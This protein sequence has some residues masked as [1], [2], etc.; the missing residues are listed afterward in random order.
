[1]KRCVFSLVFGLCI[2]LGF[3]WG[4]WA[5]ERIN[6]MAVFSLPAEM[7]VL[8]KP[9]LPY[10]TRHATDPD[11][12][13][14]VL[15]GEA[16]RHYWDSEKYPDW[17][18]G[19][20]LPNWDAAKSRWGE[21][22]L[23]EH[24]MLPFHLE[25]AYWQ[26]KSAFEAG[27]KP[28]ILKAS[29]DLG[30]YLGDAHVPLHTTENYNGQLTGQKGIHGFWE[31]RLPELFALE[32]DYWVGRA[33]YVPSIRRAAW[34]IVRDSHA[35]VE[36]VLALEK[37]LQGQFPP[38]RRYAYE[39]RNGQVVRCYSRSYSEA[40]HRALEGMVEA[41][42]RI[43]IRT[44]ASWWYT[45]WKDAG[46]PDLRRLN[47]MILPDSTTMDSAH[48]EFIDRESTEIGA[49]LPT[50]GHICCGPVPVKA[51]G[52]HRPIQ[53]ILPKQKAIEPKWWERWLSWILIA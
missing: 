43:S 45:A 20:T 41:R 44:V 12:R 32:Y 46:S 24:G 19:D 5:H 23:L 22:Y 47:L 4:F 21:A 11:K 3:G 7:L 26:L 37:Q 33:A 48:V 2:K 51:F 6:R 30:H 10:L 42:L 25:R 29:A 50:S 14:Y 13:R 16:A 17:P 36:R 34:G 53:P 52:L 8:Y 31:S 28:Q 27:N 39:T 9:H 40:Y 35:E 38:D 49:F 15:E 1:M 18:K